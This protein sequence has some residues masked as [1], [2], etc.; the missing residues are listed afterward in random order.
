MKLSK[1]TRGSFPPIK[2]TF[3]LQL[4]YEGRERRR[5]PELFRLH[6]NI[7]ICTTILHKQR[8]CMIY[9]DGTLF[10]LWAIMVWSEF[11]NILDIQFDESLYII[12]K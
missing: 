10:K 5:I 7:I 6:I 12:D 3:K 9:I 1:V 4:L 2:Q 11:V 8:I